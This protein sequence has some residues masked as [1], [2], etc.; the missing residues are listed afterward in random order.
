MFDR[1]AKTDRQAS[2]EIFVQI[3]RELQVHSKAEE[4]IFYPAVKAM[5]GNGQ[6]LIVRALQEHGRIDLLLTEISRLKPTDPRFDETF[7]TLMENVDH[8]VEEEEGE[9]FQFAEENFSEQQLAELGL[10][11]E[12]RKHSLDQEMAA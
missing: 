2:Y 8:H 9:I 4:Q 11:I 12:R 5:N 7:E 10:Q 1:A 3:R 6:R